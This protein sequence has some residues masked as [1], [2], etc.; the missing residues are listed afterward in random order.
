MAASLLGS[1]LVGI[2]NGFGSLWLVIN[3]G[4]QLSIATWLLI[5]PGG[6]TAGGAVSRSAV[7]IRPA[8]VRILGPALAAGEPFSPLVPG[9]VEKSVV[10]YTTAAA[11]DVISGVV[12]VSSVYATVRDLGSRVTHRPAVPPSGGG[13]D[14]SQGSRRAVL[15]R[16]LQGQLSPAGAG[17]RRAM[18]RRSGVSSQHACRVR[19]LLISR[20]ASNTRDGMGDLP[21]VRMGAEVRAADPLVTEPTIISPAVARVDTTPEEIAAAD[22]VVLLTDH[23]AF[24]AVDIG[25]HARH[26]LDCRRILSGPEVGTLVRRSRTSHLRGRRGLIT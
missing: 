7:R 24:L 8:C 11:L 10:E 9:P 22:T 1:S 18:W 3:V 12:L 14:A 19:P 17:P 13:G 5:R 20:T 23:E 21:L 6:A 4:L 25:R 15:L 2:E 16:R 26:V